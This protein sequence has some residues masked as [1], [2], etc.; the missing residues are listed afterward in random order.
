MTNRKYFLIFILS[1]TTIFPQETRKLW[2]F[3]VLIKNPTKNINNNKTLTPL[4]D[5]DNNNSNEINAFISDPFIPPIS[6]TMIKKENN[7]LFILES[8]YEMPL[9]N[10]S[11]AKL[12]AGRLNMQK[13]Y[14]PI[15][16]MITHI[17]FQK[18]NTRDFI[19]LNYLLANALFHT[20][21]F[22]QAEKVILSTKIHS[23][24]DNLQFLL[25]MIYES[26]GRIKDAQK[27]YYEFIKRFPQS[28]YKVTA[29]IKTQLIEKTNK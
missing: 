19:D 9:N 6:N 2:D 16:E 28:N 18:L 20:G 27:Q 5:L 1:I 7:T 8:L 22:I 15:I 10:I 25:A 24:D 4:S 3:G 14:L 23:S 26:Q 21:A 17:D 13:D 29:Q 12:L 11:Q